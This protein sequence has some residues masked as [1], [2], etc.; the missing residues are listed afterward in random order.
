MPDEAEREGVAAGAAGGEGAGGGVQ[1]VEADGDAD[2]RGGFAA[3][4]ERG[5]VEQCAER[6][7]EGVVELLG[8][9]AGCAGAAELVGDVV[10]AGS[11]GASGRPGGG[12]DRCVGVGGAG[13]GQGGVQE[14]TGLGV[15]LGA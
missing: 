8:A 12:V 14:L 15:E 6:E 10:G 7:V 5:G 13:R 3:L 1:G 11:G 2:V 4:T 9:A